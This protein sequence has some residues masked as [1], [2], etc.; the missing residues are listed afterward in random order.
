M[1]LKI[2]FFIIKKNYYLN[3]NFGVKNIDYGVKIDMIQTTLRK[4]LYNIKIYFHLNKM[5]NKNNYRWSQYVG[6]NLIKSVSISF[7]SDDPAFPD[8][9]SD[10]YKIYDSEW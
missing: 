4:L 8:R 7:G 2:A 3:G 6:L 1:K 5:E 9:K 10:E